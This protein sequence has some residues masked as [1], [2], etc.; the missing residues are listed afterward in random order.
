MDDVFT[1]MKPVQAPPT[2]EREPSAPR[3]VA[4]R[5]AARSAPQRDYVSRCAAQSFAVWR[6]STPVAT[7]SPQT[8][9]VEPSGEDAEVGPP[10]SFDTRGPTRTP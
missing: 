10:P 1:I 2:T 3:K 6:R 4:S 9:H 7:W 8:L 5:R